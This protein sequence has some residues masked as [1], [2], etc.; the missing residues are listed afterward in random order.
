MTDA[1]HQLPSYALAVS[2]LRLRFI[3]AW[4]RVAEASLQDRSELAALLSCLPPGCWQ[5]A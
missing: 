2:K 4:G 5:G 3:P 1:A